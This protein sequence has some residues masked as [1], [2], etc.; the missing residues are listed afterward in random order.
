V[1]ETRQAILTILKERGQA[2]VDQLSDQ[3]ELTPVTI[4]HHLDILRSEGLVE[5]PKVK[6]RQTPGRPQHVYALTEQATEYF[7]KNYVGF[8]DLTLR[9]IREHIGSE[10]L[11][12][13][14]QGV[15]RRMAS[16]VP[17]PLPDEP[18]P[19]RLDRVVTFLNQKGYVARWETSD[20]GY[21]LHTANCPYQGLSQHHRE[22]CIMDMTLITELLGVTPQRVAWLNA[23]EETCS[24]LVAKS[25]GNGAQPA[26]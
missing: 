14:V 5:A 25:N 23:G 22:P 13:I 24:Y 8:A 9:E 6:R 21:L 2:T 7:P 26:R 18:I 16:G 15:A 1:Q 12:S 11:E 4:R 17:H 19:H 3:L 10:Q 20:R